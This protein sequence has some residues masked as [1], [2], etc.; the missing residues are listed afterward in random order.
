MQIRLLALPILLTLCVN[1]QAS[2]ASEIKTEQTIGFL[3]SSLVNSTLKDLIIKTEAL[4]K[5]P[6][7]PINER[8]KKPVKQENPVSN[9]Q[10]KHKLNKVYILGGTENI[11]M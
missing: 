8:Y 7:Q 11:P 5:V 3:G 6:S 2:F 9:Y 10:P 1:V 4:I